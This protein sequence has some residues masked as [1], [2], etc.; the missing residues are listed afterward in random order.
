MSQ[1][2]RVLFICT[3]NSARSL[4]AEALMRDMAGDRYQVFSAGLEPSQADMRALRALKGA[5]ISTAGLRSKALGDVLDDP[6]DIVITLCNKATQECQSV[7][8]TRQ[9]LAWDFEDPVTRA[10]L[11]PFETTLT[12]LSER[13]KMFLL[14]QGKPFRARPHS[15]TPLAF[16]KNLAEDTRL[17]TLLLIH[18]QQELCVCELTEALQESQPKISRHLAQLRKSGLLQDRRDSQWV[19]Y[20][21]N[22]NVPDWCLTVLDE[23]LAANAGWIEE[24]TQRLNAMGDRPERTA[25]CCAPASATPIDAKETK[26]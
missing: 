10:G 12:E 17:R 3:A 11:R 20:S 22:P 6:F 2:Q 23:T 1:K 8:G 5:G 24:D 18:S 21:I 4:M 9:T 26:H 25:K 7:Q 16:Y 13:L 15:L 14:I 19:F